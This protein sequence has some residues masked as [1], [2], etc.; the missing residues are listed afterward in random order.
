[1]QQSALHYEELSLYQAK[2]DPGFLI[3]LIENLVESCPEIEWNQSKI[4]EN[5]DGEYVVNKAIRDNLLFNLEPSMQCS[6]ESKNKILYLEK[7]IHSF[8]NGC[9]S[10]YLKYHNVSV[11]GKTS[12]EI[13]KYQGGNHLWWHDDIGHGNKVSLLFYLNSDFEG[14]ELDFKFMLHQPKKGDI[15]IFPSKYEHRVLPIKEGVRYCINAFMY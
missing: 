6:S 12:Y 1:M 4:I 15:I 7:K 13:L 2:E 9:I 10:D 3:D 5:R 11:N 8:L 14:G